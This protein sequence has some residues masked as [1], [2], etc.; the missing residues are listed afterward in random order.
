MMLLLLADIYKHVFAVNVSIT[1]C[2]V[3]I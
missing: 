1:G 2:V 3:Q